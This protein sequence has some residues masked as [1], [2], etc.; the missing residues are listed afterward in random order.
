[1][2]HIVLGHHSPCA[3]PVVVQGVPFFNGVEEISA[4]NLT[5]EHAVALDFVK[6]CPRL[7]YVGLIPCSI[8]RP[9]HVHAQGRR[10]RY[11]IRNRLQNSQRTR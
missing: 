4:E 5:G 11:H 9:P 7:D 6:L 10:G 8:S 2:R 1:M 3:D